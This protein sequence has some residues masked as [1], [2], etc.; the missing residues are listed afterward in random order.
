MHIQ[1]IAPN[2]VRYMKQVRGEGEREMGGR[3][4]GGKIMERTGKGE[5]RTIE[6][7][8]NYSVDIK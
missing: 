4:E 5:G 8:A 6:V 2:D 1:V 3:G 7:D